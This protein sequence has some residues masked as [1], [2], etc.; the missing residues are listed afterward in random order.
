MSFLYCLRSLMGCMR[1]DQQDLPMVLVIEISFIL[2]SCLLLLYCLAF[3]TPQKNEGIK[4]DPGAELGFVMGGE[5][6]WMRA[7]VMMWG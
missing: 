6:K 3:E 7:A 1:T 4:H 2:S 5:F